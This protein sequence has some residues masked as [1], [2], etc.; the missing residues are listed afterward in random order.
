M[1]ADMQKLVLRRNEINQLCLHDAVSGLPLA[2]QYRVEVIQESAALTT[3]RVEFHAG[4]LFS[5]VR[6]EVNDG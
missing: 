2:G 5:G 6:I 4:N 1:M 3:V